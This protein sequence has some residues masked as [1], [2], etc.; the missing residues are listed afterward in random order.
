MSES[1]LGGRTEASALHGLESVRSAV[2][3]LAGGAH[4]TLDVLSRELDPRLYDQAEFLAVVR[5][6]A[7]R[8]RFVRIRALV[9]DSESLVRN[10]HRFLELARRLSSYVELR[11]L[12]EEDRQFNEAFLVVDER[13]YLHQRVSDLYEA[14]LNDNNPLKA[15]ELTKLFEDLWARADLDPNLRRLHL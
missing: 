15:K 3:E 4:R 11:R 2:F 6:L 14:E 1:N 12:G 7:I 8:S 5:Q 10:D 9:R 13:A